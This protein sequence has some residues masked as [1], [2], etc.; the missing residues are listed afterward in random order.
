MV[1]VLSS[2]HTATAAAQSVSH[3]EISQRTLIRLQ[4]KLKWTLWKR[5]YRKN[6]G[7][8]IGTIVGVLYA[9]GGLA[10]LVALFLGTT[11]WAGEG[12]TFPLVVRGLGAVTVLAWFLIPVLAFGLDD[13]LD[14]RAFALFPRTAE[15]LQPGMFAAAGLS[16]PSLFT[17][18]AVAIATGFELLWLILFGQGAL[19]IVLAAL[20]LIP[21]NLAAFALCLL[22][23]RAWFAHSASRASSRSGREVGGILGFLLL[24][25]AIYA[26]SLGAQKV[27]DLDVTLLREWLP[28]IVEILAWTP[29]GALFAVP[30]DLAEG[31]VLSALLRA[32]IGA[33]TI[34]LVWLW[35]RRSIDASLTS[36]L[37]GD[38]SSGD[39]K[40][41]P[42][43][44]RFVRPGPFG[45][46]MGKSLRYWR[47]DTR[48]LATLGIYPVIIVFFAA[49][50]LMLPE[51]RGMMLG[52]AIF[53]CGMSGI[54]LANEIGFDGPSGWVNLVTAMPARAN[55]LGRIAAQAVLMV[56]GVVVAMIVLPLL[57][58]RTDLIPLAVMGALGAMVC[59]WGISMV[60]SVLLP[61]PS[62][63]P[64]TNPMKDKSASSSNAMLAM[65]VAM[66]GVFVPLLPAIGVGVWG[67]IV[68]S[69]ALTLLAGALALVAGAVMFL[70]GL[71]IAAVRLDA[72]YPDVFQKVRNHL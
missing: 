18:V 9:L 30:M 53:M 58:G 16:L 68:G 44:P 8:L 59:G 34:A 63:P 41:S 64:G 4:L 20:V 55:L 24:F 50:G 56:P 25:A 26:F 11:L 37:T 43:V 49:M 54:S 35:W 1:G 38:A 32:A 10:G 21:A 12:E 57:Y 70:V 19:W 62:S 13:T 6:V 51:S 69:L 31:R 45:A 23:P 22:L 46:V 29:V 3:G 52:M 61:Y 28:R 15:E 17:L 14:P 71:R 67:A 5:S 36:A 7:K 42:L 2:E 65:A 33:V 72:R 66:V 39:A 47:R 48:Y 40:V 27:D 60:V